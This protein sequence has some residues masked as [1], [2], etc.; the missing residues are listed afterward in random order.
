MDYDILTAGIENVTIGEGLVHLTLLKASVV[1]DEDKGTVHE[2]V[3]PPNGFLQL[4]DQLEKAV[5]T[6]EERGVFA[7]GGGNE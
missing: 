6:L 4:F 2:L 3:M 5:A 7:G 1:E